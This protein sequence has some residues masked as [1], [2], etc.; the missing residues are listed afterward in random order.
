MKKL[1]LNLNYRL[2]PTE[3]QAFP[4]NKHITEHLLRALVAM[5]Y[6]QGMNRTDTRTWGSIMDALD[7][8]TAKDGVGASNEIELEK[9][10]AL[11]LLDVVN[12]CLDNSK[13]PPM[14]ASW[15]STVLAHLE[16]VKAHGEPKLEAVK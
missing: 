16:E 8:A 11:W 1:N 3:R 6:P 14:M 10:E 13:V 12:W 7:I 2:K 5:R 9:S 15:V 4:E